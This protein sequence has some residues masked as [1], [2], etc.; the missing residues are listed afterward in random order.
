MLQTFSVVPVGDGSASL[1]NA[2]RTLCGDF[3]PPAQN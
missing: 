1:A 2:R 3:A